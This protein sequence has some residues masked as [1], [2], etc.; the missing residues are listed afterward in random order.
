MV[1]K[2]RK[3]ATAAGMYRVKLATYSMQA[4]RPI[5]PHG[6]QSKSKAWQLVV[7]YANGIYVKAIGKT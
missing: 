4:L 2:R 3:K 1:V 7:T 6:E 5:L